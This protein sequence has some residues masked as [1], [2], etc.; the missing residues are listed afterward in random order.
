MST[1]TENKQGEW[2]ALGENHSIL[3]TSCFNSNIEVP[4]TD[5]VK[6]EAD[7]NSKFVRI[8]FN[9]LPQS[10]RIVVT[11]NFEKTPIQLSLGQLLAYTHTEIN[12]IEFAFKYVM[13]LDE[14]D[15][16]DSQFPYLTKDASQAFGKK[17][18]QLYTLTLPQRATFSNGA[19]PPKSILR[20]GSV[21][22]MVG[23][24]SKVST[25]YF[26]PWDEGGNPNSAQVSLTFTPSQFYDP[27][28]LGS[29]IGLNIG[30]SKDGSL[31]Q[32]TVSTYGALG[33]TGKGVNSDAYNMMDIMLRESPTAENTVNHKFMLYLGNR[34]S[35]GVDKQNARIAQQQNQP[36]TIIER[37]NEG[38]ANH[39]ITLGSP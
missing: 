7:V 13:G 37:A 20:V 22:Q 14:K 24:F 33:S 27:A 2:D 34:D 10:F 23:V 30:Y 16:S 1:I 9:F 17:I 11:S 25:E 39:P 32:K 12:D 26:G 35:S 31:D 29:R 19:P 5:Y 6:N 21:I 38:M 28:I 3:I 15:A 8:R 4:D 18:Q 36:R